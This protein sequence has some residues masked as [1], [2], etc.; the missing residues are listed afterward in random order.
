MDGIFELPG[1]NDQSSRKADLNVKFM[2]YQNR[3][4]KITFLCCFQ[5][6]HHLFP[7]MPQFRHPQ[8]QSRVRELARKHNLPFIEY[9]YPE[10]VVKTYENLDEVAKELTK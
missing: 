1:E 5:I 6:E 2:I 4:M 3:L 7:T 9:T 8:I 10:A